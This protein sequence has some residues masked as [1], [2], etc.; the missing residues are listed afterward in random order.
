MIR[1]WLSFAVALGSALLPVRTLATELT[2]YYSYEQQGLLDLVESFTEETGV[3]VRTRWVSLSEMVDVLHEASANRSGLEVALVPNDYAGMHEDFQLSHIIPA[4]LSHTIKAQAWETARVGDRYYGAPLM[5]GNHLMLY[6]NRALVDAPATT[7]EALHEWQRRDGAQPFDTIAWDYQGMYWMAPFL[8]AHASASNELEFKLERD[9]LVRGLSDYRALAEA[10]LVDPKCDDDCALRRFRNGEVA[11][12]I[13]GDWALG[14]LQ[15]ALGENL[16]VS[17]LPALADKP[18]RSTY[19]AHVLVFPGDGLNG[20]H[21]AAL[22]ALINYLQSP[23]IQK[24]LADRLKVLPVEAEAQAYTLANAGT[25]LKTVIEA[26]PHAIPLP[27]EKATVRV[28]DAIRK[29]W[30]RYQAGVVSAEE[31]ADIILRL[32]NRELAPDPL[33]LVYT[34]GMQPQTFEFIADFTAQTGIE[35]EHRWIHQDEIKVELINMVDKGIAPDIVMVPSDHIGLHR[36]MEYSRID[37][38]RIPHNINDELWHTGLA[39][40][41][42]YGAPVTQGNHLLLY[43]NKDHVDEP[44]SDWASLIERAPALAAKGVIP[45]TWHYKAMYWLMPYVAAHGGMPMDGHELT[46]NTPAMAKGLDNYRWLAEQGIVDT[47]CDYPC[48]HG[49]F[50][51]G[52]AAYTIDGDWA[53]Q[54]YASKLGDKLG[55][56][57]LPSLNGRTLIS[58][59]STQVF[60]FPQHGL[61]GPKHDAMM[62]FLNYAL[63]AEAQK[64]LVDEFRVLP[65]E[66]SAISYARDNADE[67]LATVFKQLEQAR[68]IPSE[69]AMSHAW[70]AIVRGFF[71]HQAGLA[72]GAEAS[73]LMQRLA[74]REIARELERDNRRMRD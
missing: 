41:H 70:G 9:A 3:A 64:K 32:I 65:V 21:K 17:A 67:H 68:P 20:P 19:S 47:E 66:R 61:Q 16:A 73:S 52:Q 7:W 18:M 25:N 42:Y 60:A 55:V 69:S 27:A 8:L 46:L 59:Y 2:F 15:E 40:G 44:A 31:T 50:V 63:S 74:E 30:L 48:A 5:L 58:P 51:A 1:F 22:R 38:E 28:W 72:T 4:S 26:L 56:A 12:T 62:A 71:R 10:Q 14:Q 43:Y 57:L 53:L 11:Y 33:T 36:Y 54:E 39:D 24:R 13:N 37:R 6:Y 35:V 49:A 34:F 45:I 23:P 29:G